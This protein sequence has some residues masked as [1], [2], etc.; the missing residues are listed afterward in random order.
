M[1]ETI[2]LMLIKANV[3]LALLIG[4]P[5]QVIDDL[6]EGEM[7]LYVDLLFL[8]ARFD[9]VDAG[10]CDGLDRRLD[11]H[12]SPGLVG[13]NSIHFSHDITWVDTVSCK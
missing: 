6:A 3:L 2:F 13:Q 9:K 11:G 5:F 7:P 4:V 10:P 8:A 12:V 1:I